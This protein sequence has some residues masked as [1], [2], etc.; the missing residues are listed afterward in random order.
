MLLEKTIRLK[1]AKEEAGK[2]IAEYRNER[3][4]IYSEKQKTFAGSKDDLKHKMDQDTLAKRRQ[5]EQ[6]VKANKEKVIQR[7]LEM[8]YDI[9]PELHRN[10]RMESSSSM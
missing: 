6:D 5:I 3:E 2:E 8:V 7:L 4:K 9:R 10:M 1:E